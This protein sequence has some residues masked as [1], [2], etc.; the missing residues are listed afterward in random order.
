MSLAIRWMVYDNIRILGIDEVQL[1]IAVF[2]PVM[3]DHKACGSILEVIAPRTSP[4]RP[5][6]I[7]LVGNTDSR[8]IGVMLIVSAHDTII[9][10]VVALD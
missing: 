3:P 6:D 9:I 7:I 8:G 10:D 4:Q 5:H 2:Y 1:A